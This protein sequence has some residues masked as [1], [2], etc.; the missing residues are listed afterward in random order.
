MASKIDNYDKKIL[1]EMD[2]NSRINVSALAKK[3]NLPKET[4]TYRLKKLIANGYIKNFYAIINVSS[5]GYRYYKIS[6]KLRGAGSSIERELVEYIKGINT[7][8]NLRVIEGHS[9]ISFIAI[10]RT[11]IGLKKFLEELSRRYGKYIIE[12]NIQKIITS[13][14]LSHRLLHNGE[15]AQKKF[16]HVEP[17]AGKFEDM[18]KK[19]LKILSHFGRMKIID[20]AN[21]IKEEPAVVA[22]HIKRLENDGVIV[23]YST[24]LNF[25]LFNFEFVEID[26]NLKHHGL[27]NKIIDFFHDTNTCVFA[28]EL[29]GNDDLSLELYVEND[30]HLRKILSLFK[31]RFDDNYNS[32]RVSRIY[33]EH[34]SNWSPFEI[35]ED[36]TNKNK[37]EV[38]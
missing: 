19:I 7:C 1:Y 30:E 2:L 5:F 27:I 26:I 28:Y 16:E 15:K 4:V 9:D 11:A 24:A 14:K 25:E 35:E 32:Y 23:G 20:I 6:L 21:K 10:H 17:P 38:K 8:C 33:E 37:E 31:E 34:M 12:K 36:Q 18:D 29:I 13:Y 22:Y 3:V